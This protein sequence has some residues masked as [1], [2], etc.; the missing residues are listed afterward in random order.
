MRAFGGIGRCVSMIAAYISKGS[1]QAVRARA[2]AQRSK[3]R[4]HRRARFPLRGAYAL[5]GARIKLRVRSNAGLLLRAPP[6]LYGLQQ[7]CDPDDFMKQL[8]VFAFLGVKVALEKFDVLGVARLKLCD[9]TGDTIYLLVVI[10][11]GIG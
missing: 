1:L 9:A 3:M 4:R 2:V 11:G 6:C 8:V 10:G 5:V 7:P